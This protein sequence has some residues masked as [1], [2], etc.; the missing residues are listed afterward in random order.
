MR[1][2]LKNF[3]ACIGLIGA[4]FSAGNTFANESRVICGESVTADSYSGF[5]P[6]WLDGGAEIFNPDKTIKLGTLSKDSFSL[7]SVLNQ[8]GSFGSIY[9][10]NSIFNSSGVYGSNS[11]SISVCSISSTEAVS[12]QIWR[13]G[14]FIGYLTLNSNLQGAINPKTVLSALLKQQILNV[15]G[16]VAYSPS[17]PVFDAI[18]PGIPSGLKGE[19]I[20]S[21]QINLSWNASTDNV[22]VVAY[23]LYSGGSL[24][25]AIDSSL[26]SFMLTGLGPA[27]TYNFRVSACDAAKNCSATSPSLTITTPKISQNITTT[28]SSSINFG[29]NI[30]LNISGG[31]SGNSIY[32]TNLTASICTLK[33]LTLTAVEVG[34]CIIT[35]NQAGN[36]TFLAATQVTQNIVINPVRPDSPNGVSATVGNGQA[37]VSFTAPSN[38][39][40]API[41]SYRVTSSPGGVFATGTASPIN[42]SGLSNGTSY[43]FIVTATNNAGTS[44]ASASSNV[45][46]PITVPGAPTGVSAVSGN[47]VATVSFTAPSNNG[48]AA[49]TSYT[50]TSSGGQTATGTSSP[51]N[52]VGLAS[53][54]QYTFTVTASNSSGSSAS[55][56]SSNVAIYYANLPLAPS[57]TAVAG[58]A[59]ATVNVSSAA[60]TCISGGSISCYLVPAGSPSYTVT[61]SPGGIVVTSSSPSVVVSGLTNGV[62]YNFKATMTTNTGTSVASAASNTVT[63]VAPVT[64]P[65][66]PT[67]VSATAGNSSSTVTFA[68]P[69]NNGGAPITSYRVTSSPGGFSAVGNGSPITV[70]GLTNGTAYTFTVTA[71]NSAGTGAASGLSNSVTPTSPTTT[72]SLVSGWNLIGN[73]YNVSIDVTALLSDTANVTTVWKWIPSTTK[74]AFYAP[75]LSSQA[76][77]DYVKNKGY[78]VLSTVSGG[79]GFWVN[80]KQAFDFQVPNGVQVLSTDFQSGGT[81]QLISGWSLIAIGDNKEPSSFNATL[82][83]TP[84]VAGA[85]ASNVTTLWAWDAAATKWYFYAPSLEASGGLINY[86]N[87]KG[88]LDFNT[89]QKMLTPGVGFWVNRQ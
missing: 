7:D 11:S 9:G 23:R 8:Y 63:P 69:S 77:A 73:S 87:N 60:G 43:S 4:F 24:I 33:G 34:T 58:N 28:T 31:G 1:L 39:G 36:A 16:Q 41:S 88:Y 40:G 59:S 42:V 50:V 17:V 32:L 57:V 29:D 44:V 83:L 61:S 72:I 78:E 76:L 10:S 5:I 30:N 47:A 37:S 85:V 45:V 35:A 46:T 68:A 66:A 86:T 75:T 22:G 64:V 15:S 65:G 18:A 55:S 70:T 27:T 12:P 6:S 82:S 81:K 84:P 26:T 25:N 80:A 74:W 38:T 53:G 21:D 54:V 3:C 89:N 14:S 20:S 71:A 13:N 19:I 48:G 79:E 49:I 2:N 67:G 51:I 56:S 52:V 62:S